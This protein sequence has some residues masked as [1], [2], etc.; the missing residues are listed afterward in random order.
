MKMRAQ[1]VLSEQETRWWKSCSRWSTPRTKVTCRFVTLLRLFIA[2]NLRDRIFDQYHPGVWCILRS[3]RQF[4]WPGFG[5]NATKEWS[6]A[7]RLIDFYM[8]KIFTN[9][10]QATLNF[11]DPRNRGLSRHFRNI[12]RT[13]PEMTHQAIH[14]CWLDAWGAAAHHRLIK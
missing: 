4:D 10:T 13:C 11:I 2:A 3:S 5:C 9:A 8:M 1:R 12:G 14:V 7:S 6:I